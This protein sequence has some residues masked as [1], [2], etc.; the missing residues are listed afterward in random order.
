M[1]INT[2]IV[3]DEFPDEI[4]SQVQVISPPVITRYFANTGGDYLGGYAGAEPPEGAV[5]VDSPPED[6]RDVFNGNAWV[7][8][9]PPV[10]VPQTVTRRQA[11]QALFLAGL[12]DSV[13]PAIAAIPDVTQRRL[14]QI[15][16]EDSL[17]FD[18]KR[19]LVIGIGTA[20]GLT[21]A[22]IDELFTTASTL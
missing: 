17:E 21:S 2:E 13:E 19:P 14:A 1:D 5:E 16:W 20:L 8:Y 22:G 11:R 18:R 10:T 12:L 6:A 7:K 4:Q 9:A 15:E 3:S